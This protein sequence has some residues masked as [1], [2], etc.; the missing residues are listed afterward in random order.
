MSFLNTLLCIICA[1]GV[2]SG[3]ILMKC[4]SKAWVETG[5][6]F[7]TTVVIWMGSAFALYG[8]ASLGWVYILKEVPLSVAYPLLSITFCLVPVAGYLFFNEALNWQNWIA[9]ILI[10]TGICLASFGHHVTN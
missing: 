5:T 1:F 10:I 9:S 6:L 8:A 4:T 2:A 7:D 3:Q